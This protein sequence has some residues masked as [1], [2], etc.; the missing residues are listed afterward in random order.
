MALQF[1]RG[2]NAERLTVTP[3]SG[4]PIWTTDT[5]MLYV[6]DGSTQG[7]IAISN[8]ASVYDQQLNTTSTVTFANATITNQLLVTTLRFPDGSTF[9]TAQT[10]TNVFNQSLNT[11]DSVKFANVTS[12]NATVESTLYI[13]TDTTNILYT[14]GTGNFVIQS[15]LPGGIQVDASSGEIILTSGIGTRVDT[16]RTVNQSSGIQFDTGWIYPYQS[17]VDIGTSANAW[18][19]L[20]LKDTGTLFFGTNTIAVNS[21]GTLL[22][23]G[24][25]V[26][27]GNPFDQTLNTSSHV[28]F[29][30]VT[31]GNIYARETIEFGTSANPPIIEYDTAQN[32][33]RL[34]ITNVNSGGIILDSGANLINFSGKARFS[35]EIQ[36]TTTTSNLTINASGITPVSGKVAN[37]GSSNNPWENLYLSNTGTVYLGTSTISISNTGSLLVNGGPVT[38][39]GSN[40]F[41]QT[42]NTTS[43]VTFNDLRVS[44]VIYFSTL[45]SAYIGYGGELIMDG[46]PG[47]V[48][49]RGGAE[50][51]TLRSSSGIFIQAS[52][53]LPGNAVTNTT[54]GNQFNLWHDIYAKSTAT[55]RFGSNTLG[56]SST[57]TIQVNGIELQTGNP[58]NQ[59][60]NTSSSVTFAQI[61]SNNFTSTNLMLFINESTGVSPRGF[62]WQII[63]GG[64]G[65]TGNLTFNGTYLESNRTILA[66]ENAGSEFGF[67][68]QNQSSAGGATA[69]FEAT[70]NIN[71]RVQFGIESNSISANYGGS[72]GFITYP[73]NFVIDTGNLNIYQSNFDLGSITR[74]NSSSTTVATVSQSEIFRYPKTKDAAKV[75]IKARQGNDIHLTELSIITDGT[76]IWLTEYGT[77]YNNS[78]LG[79]FT[80]VIDSNDVVVKMTATTSTQ[81][82]VK[83]HSIQFS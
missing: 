41:N 18:R 49:I 45:T 78:S 1:R 75:S 82:I 24:A 15:N 31:A 61:N 26:S 13:G 73:N 11:Q 60:L 59:T 3:A 23:N 20:Y 34:K 27:G 32:I 53:L 67:S 43:N 7:G 36:A 55:I 58:F 14:S 39:I 50:P 69:R 9:T 80:A 76:D 12:T 10:G 30:S 35:Q 66:K 33:N 44:N 6:G 63:D 17:N 52:S 56:L 54:I 25:A 48:D 38:G 68:A 42:L 4:E 70:N 62:Q 47:G 21:T 81:M 19:N 28:T 65:A 74:H 64:G 8:T 83:T 29:Q 22:V 40:P 79:T 72:R 5:R 51:V 46:S 57:G 2:T 77:I 71:D 37:L 16:L